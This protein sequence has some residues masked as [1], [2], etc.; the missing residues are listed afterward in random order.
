ME[1]ILNAPKG[2]MTELL[3]LI[4]QLT[5]RR[6]LGGHHRKELVTAWFNCE[7][8]LPSLP[9]LAWFNG[10]PASL[11]ISCADGSKTGNHLPRNPNLRGKYKRSFLFWK[12]LPGCRQN[13]PRNNGSLFASVGGMS[14]PASKMVA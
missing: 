14:I 3:N 4:E 11:G 12:I 13:T 1:T 2:T 10:F 5:G 9:Q 6:F 8:H 7:D